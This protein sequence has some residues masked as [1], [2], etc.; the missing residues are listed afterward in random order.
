MNTPYKYSFRSFQRTVLPPASPGFYVI[1]EPI[2]YEI[3]DRPFEGV[4]ISDE[5]ATRLGH[6]LKEALATDNFQPVL[7][8]YGIGQLAKIKSAEQLVS[9]FGLNEAEAEKMFRIL[10]IGRIIFKES[11][12]V[13][14]IIRGRDDI[15]DRYRSM[16]SLD[17][18]QL[19]IALIN[20]RYMLVMDEVL[21]KGSPEMLLLSPLEVFAPV[22]MR[23]VHSVILIHNHVSGDPT[24][25]AA[26]YEFTKR[27][28]VAAATLSIDLLDHVII[29]KDS[30]SSA[31][32]EA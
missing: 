28:R 18:E 15:F 9:T 30:C 23:K 19:I 8:G 7:E 21:A 31:I 6:L 22:I 3:N 11:Q 25:S 5:T 2:R 29:G 32:S 12:T 4:P 14:P 1:Q 26:D 27:M 24:P 17:H 13:N 16:C 20:S 10:S